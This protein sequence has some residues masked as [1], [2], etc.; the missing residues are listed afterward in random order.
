M[1][2]F[3]ST[4]FFSQC[5]GIHV[6]KAPRFVKGE[7]IYDK[8]Q[9]DNLSLWPRSARVAVMRVRHTSKFLIFYSKNI[10][11][12]FNSIKTDAIVDNLKVM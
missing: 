10:Y 8:K 12:F 9:P 3:E 11:I 7:Q 5:Q 6:K 1:H 4:E 2:L